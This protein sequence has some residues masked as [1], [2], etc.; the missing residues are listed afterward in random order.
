MKNEQPKIC[1]Y[2]RYLPPDPSGAGKQAVTLARALRRKGIE[3]ALLGDLFPGVD[4]EHTIDG[5]PVHWVKGLPPDWSYPTL[6]LYWARLAA[7]LFALR[8]RFDVLQ[9]HAA[10]FSVIGAI[11]TGRLLN[12][13]VVVRTSLAGELARLGESPSERFKRRL[14]L[15]AHRYVALSSEISVEAIEGGLPQNRTNQIP[16]GV[17][18]SI[19]HPVE[20]P[21]KLQLRRD[22][23]LPVDGR[24]MIF[25][26]VFAERKSLHWLVDVIGPLLERNDLTL[27]L[28]GGP[29]RDEVRTRYAARLREQVARSPY[30]DRIVMRGHQSD[31]ERFL[32]AADLY[33][34]PSTGEGLPNALLEAM[35]CG[36]VPLATRTSGTEDVIQDGV[37]GFLFEPRDAGSFVEAVDRCLADG[38]AALRAMSRAAVGRIRAQYTVDAI[39]DL[40]LET[41]RQ[42]C[43]MRT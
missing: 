5:V 40:Y 34:L 4:R 23:N 14:L 1:I 18:A 42:A 7:K 39:A 24:I 37:S 12:K 30:R 35:A 6:F 43:R 38:G 26:G 36:L 9:V 10:P 28:V 31:V 2:Q 27:L 20:T 11:P 29:T 19:F 32:Q 16:N 17:D 8:H 41:Y 3:V 22:L 13:G 21:R 15:L 33:V 25:H